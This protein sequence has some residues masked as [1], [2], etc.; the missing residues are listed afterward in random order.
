MKTVNYMPKIVYPQKDREVKLYRQKSINWKNEKAKGVYF[1]KHYMHKAS[2]FIHAYIRQDIAHQEDRAEGV[3]LDDR[4]L[5]V[6]NYRKL[7]RAEY[8]IEWKGQTLKVLAIDGFEHKG[9]ELKLTCQMIQADTTIY[10]KV[11]EEKL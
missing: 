10:K 11:E 3:F 8:F 9:T 1:A 6:I 2:K 4:Y 7:P 5:V